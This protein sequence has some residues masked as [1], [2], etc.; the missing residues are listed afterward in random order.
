MVERTGSHGEQQRD[1]KWE[2]I[3]IKLVR[4]SIK[5]AKFLRRA[6]F[7]GVFRGVH[8]KWVVSAMVCHLRF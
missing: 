1:R 4:E 6:D 5:R 8:A 2:C 3:V 7:S